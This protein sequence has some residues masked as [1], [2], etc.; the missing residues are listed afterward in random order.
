MKPL[1]VD[2]RERKVR[3]KIEQEERNYPDGKKSP[4]KS[5]ILSGLLKSYTEYAESIAKFIER[6]TGRID[7]MLNYWK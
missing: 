4:F 7:L 6:S 5:K 3:N 1:Y 2:G